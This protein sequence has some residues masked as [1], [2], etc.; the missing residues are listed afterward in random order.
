MFCLHFK[1]KTLELSDVINIT[2][3]TV[4]KATYV[5]GPLFFGLSDF[6]VLGLCYSA[7]ISLRSQT[8]TNLLKSIVFCP[9]VNVIKLFFFVTNSWPKF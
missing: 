3:T 1:I 5:L 4:I 8:N 9:G 7:D 6:Q 2:N